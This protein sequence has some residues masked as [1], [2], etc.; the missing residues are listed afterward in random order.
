MLFH[1]VTEPV[2]HWDRFNV[3]GV[4]VV[5]AVRVEA[6]GTDQIFVVGTE[7]EPLTAL[8]EVG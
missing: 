1:E 6:A 7:R 2:R 3:P 5:V 8:R 4:L